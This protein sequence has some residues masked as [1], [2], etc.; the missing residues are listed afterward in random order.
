MIVALN[1]SQNAGGGNYQLYDR[2]QSFDNN[3][4]LKLY[5]MLSGKQNNGMFWL[6]SDDSVD[7]NS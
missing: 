7:L 3:L 1:D 6:R 4:K 5:L 2:Q